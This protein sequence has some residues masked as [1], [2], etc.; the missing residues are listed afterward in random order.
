M[1]DLGKEVENA[2]N[3]LKQ[4]HLVEYR[5]PVKNNL[6]SPEDTSAISITHRNVTEYRRSFAFPSVRDHRART[7]RSVSV[8]LDLPKG[9]RIDEKLFLENLGAIL[10]SLPFLKELTITGRYKPYSISRD[11]FRGCL[12]SLEKL[13]C[14]VDKLLIASWNSLRRRS[15]R[16]FRGF[17]DIVN[18]PPPEILAYDMASLE[19]L[20]T[21]AHFAARLTDPAKI[22]HISLHASRSRTRPTLCHL[23]NLLGDQLISLRVNRTIVKST[24]ISEE[25]VKKADVPGLLWESDSPLMVCCMLRTPKLKYLEI[26]D[27]S[28][29]VSLASS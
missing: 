10:R 19:Y 25:E 3:I 20:E 2:F 5:S 18:G 22:T 21:S 27:V 4:H 15:I 9:A 28:L 12:F 17:L 26:R 7:V 13:H 16:D 14:N 6:R 24:S 11:I 23:S 1:P 29:K 8:C